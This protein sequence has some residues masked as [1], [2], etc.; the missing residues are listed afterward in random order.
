MNQAVGAVAGR[1]ARFG[2]VGVTCTVL[3][4]GVA[5]AALKWL[6]ASP[7]MANGVGFIVAL[8]ASWLGQTLYTF[9]HAVSLGASARFV[10]VASS[11]ALFSSVVVYALDHY[12][13]LPDRGTVILA[14]IAAACL[15]FALHSLW[16]FRQRARAS[17]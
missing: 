8:G 5:M 1:L 13:P 15:S 14:A 9:G 7:V 2:L 6:G 17:G 10:V 11:A 12:T 3:H 4:A 16:T